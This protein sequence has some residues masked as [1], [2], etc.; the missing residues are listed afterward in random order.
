MADEYLGFDFVDESGQTVSWTME[1][2]YS[3]TLDVI[4]SPKDDS[5]NTL[6]INYLVTFPSADVYIITIY[7]QIQYV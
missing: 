1:G 4:Q 5:G 7:L 6:D 3:N 2:T